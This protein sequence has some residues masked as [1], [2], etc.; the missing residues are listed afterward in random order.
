MMRF[1][2][3]PAFQRELKR[4]EKKYKSLSED[5]YEFSNIVSAVPLGN[6]RHFK[7]ITQTGALYIIKARLFCRY[8]K[9]SSLR[10]VYAYLE[11]DQCIE[12]IELYYKGEKE[13]ENHDRIRKYLSNYQTEL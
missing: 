9:G 13:N 8:L 6:S 1:D 2:K 3:L 11:Q 4:L 12:F 5:L 10:I 7:T